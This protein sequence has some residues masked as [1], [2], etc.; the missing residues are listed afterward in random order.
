[1]GEEPGIIWPDA[2]LFALMERTF[3]DRIIDSEDHLVVQACA[4]REVL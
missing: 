1:L 2:D 3:E 4:G